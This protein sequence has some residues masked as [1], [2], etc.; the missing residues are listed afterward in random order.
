[1]KVGDEIRSLA[2]FTSTQRTA[3]RKLLKK[4][5]KW[6][7]SS[8]LDERFRKEVLDDPKSFTKLDLGI[9]LD[10]YSET[11]Q[12]VR[13]LYENGSRQNYSER[14]LS[15]VSF[16]GS[17]IIE[18]LQSAL[19]NGSNVGFDTAIAT[20]ALG[21]PGALASYFVHPD[22]IVE[23]QVLLLQHIEFFASKRRSDSAT[24]PA[25]ASSAQA[26]PH[27]P[28]P[29]A[30]YFML[31]AD[32]VDRSAQEESAVTVDER[33]NLPGL[34]PQRAKAFVRWN[35][36]EDAIICARSGR[37]NVKSASLKRKHIDA[38][39]DK[40]V[41]LSKK[42]DVRFANGT[43]NLTAIREELSKDDTIKPLY[44][45]SSCRSRFTGI[46]NGPKCMKLATL[47]TSITMQKACE[48]DDSDSK[49]GFPFA[50]LQVRQEGAGPADLVS[51]L[52]HSHLVERVA[53]LLTPISRSVADLQTLRD[54]TT[55]LDTHLKSRYQEAAAS[56][57]PS[58]GE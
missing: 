2:R 33:E 12:N 19:S 23:L 46:D 22:N 1:M 8:S 36:T 16:H 18:Q 34:A 5:R 44:K 51:A 39:F 55:I 57:A 28:A 56:G 38:F 10:D 11:L 7:G 47:D 49:S 6:T 58:P 4:F 54:C 53:R 13:S 9:L 45:I 24:T 25:S 35:N 26:V 3:F 20:V 42:K 43:Q 17:S 14:S 21:E 15:G 27:G 37:S 50:I 31:V 30:D 48:D 41:P 40:S 52:D 32:N 29:D